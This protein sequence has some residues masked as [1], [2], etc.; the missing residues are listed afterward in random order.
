MKL[1]PQRPSTKTAPSRS[2][3][4]GR[5]SLRVAWLSVVA[6]P[7]AFVGAAIVG[8]GLLSLQGYELGSEELLRLTFGPAHQNVRS[9]TA[10]TEG[11]RLLR[12][13]RAHPVAD[14]VRS[15]SSQ[16]LSIM[17]SFLAAG[18]ETVRNCRV[19]ALIRGFAGP[20]SIP[21][22]HR[23]E[24]SCSALAARSAGQRRHDGGDVS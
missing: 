10:R 16:L 2:L 23:G 5:R 14:S 4:N 8:E 19:T 6:I 1:T 22:D 17:P 20:L 18:E 3:A 24:P 12:N 7:L 13:I 15:S 21:P 11:C 9:A